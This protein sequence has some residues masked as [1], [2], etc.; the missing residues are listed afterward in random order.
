MLTNSSTAALSR[1]VDRHRSKDK[2]MEID[3]PRVSSP[4]PSQVS[5][6]R[7]YGKS[8]VING[9]HNKEEFVVDVVDRIALDD[10]EEG[11]EEEGAEEVEETAR[12]EDR[13][14]SRRRKLS[15]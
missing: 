4:I 1:I 13:R 12:T 7:K 10:P 5:I 15:C 9:I 6:E 2:T 8:M 3:K 14:R 11:T